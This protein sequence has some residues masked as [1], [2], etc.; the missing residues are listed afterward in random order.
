MT[1]QPTR[2]RLDFHRE[3]DDVHHRVIWLFAKVTEAVTACTDALLGDDTAVAQRV[4]DGEEEI[5]DA[6]SGLEERLE[7]LLLL[8]APVA[9]DLRYVLSLIRIVPELERSG[10]LADHIARRA[11]TGLASQLSPAMRGVFEQMGTAAIG[12]WRQAS[13]A[14]AD[15]DPDAAE[16]L[17]ADDDVI[18]DLHRQ[19][20]DDLLESGI[21]PAIA[22]EATLLARFYERLGDHAVHIADRVRYAAVGR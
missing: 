21:D 4:R 9:R 20:I 14:F 18:D 5:D 11:G 15:R 3:L 6:M 2:L 10:D 17:E 22:S 16:R 1:D 7:R 13:D 12:L 19:L 8:Q